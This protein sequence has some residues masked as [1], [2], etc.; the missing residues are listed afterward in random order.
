MGIVTTLHT[1]LSN[2]AWLFFLAL[3]A[4]GTWRAIRGEALD[5]SYLGALAIGQ[6]LVWVQ[7]VLGV[8][9]WGNIGMVSVPRPWVHW[10]YGLFAAVFI[11]GMYFAVLKGDDSN[12]GQWV[13]AFASFFLFGIALRGITTATF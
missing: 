6:I 1:G 9:L 4:W 10:L 5:G 12:R 2:T 8:F 7:G 11:P 3:G 13:M